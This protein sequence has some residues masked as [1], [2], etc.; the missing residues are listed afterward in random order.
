MNI[1]EYDLHRVHLELPQPIGDSQVIFRDHWLTALEL[2]TDTGLNGIGFE[3]QQGKPI[4]GLKQLKEMFEFNAW[5]TL[6][7]AHPLS[8]AMS[9]SDARGGNVGAAAMPLATET[10]IWDLVGQFENLPLY[11]L[12]GGDNPHVRAY[13][14]T[15]DYHLDDEQFRQKLEE[16]V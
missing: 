3:L 13:G 8:L 9:I 2:R 16:C 12:F 15:L 14:S 7:G 11:K 4:A 5:P 10:A 1:E 6:K